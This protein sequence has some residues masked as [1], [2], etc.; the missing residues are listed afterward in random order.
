MQLLKR[1]TVILLHLQLV[2]VSVLGK[3]DPY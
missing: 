1:Y 2:K 3:K